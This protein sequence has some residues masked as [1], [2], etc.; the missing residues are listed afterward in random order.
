MCGGQGREEIK[1]AIKNWRIC[2]QLDGSW[3]SGLFK[4]KL[5]IKCKQSNMV[6]IIIIPKKPFKGSC[7][8]HLRKMNSY[9]LVCEP[10]KM[11]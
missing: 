5:N 9:K 3:T 1:L 11:I 7:R 10:F 2:Q 8:K 6:N 4:P